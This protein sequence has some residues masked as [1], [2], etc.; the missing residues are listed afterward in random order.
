MLL[1]KGE[2]GNELKLWGWW[3]G[4]PPDS[5]IIVHP[6]QFWNWINMATTLFLYMAELAGNTGNSNS[7]MTSHWKID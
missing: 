1:Y 4:A 2:L 3:A 5:V 6:W 7:A